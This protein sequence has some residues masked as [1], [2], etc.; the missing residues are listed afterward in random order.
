MPNRGSEPLNMAVQ[1]AS[2]RLAPLGQPNRDSSVTKGSDSDMQRPLF[3]LANLLY[4]HFQ[5]CMID[6]ACMNSVIYP[7][8]YYPLLLSCTSPNLVLMKG[9]VLYEG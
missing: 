7:F 9:S 3:S 4:L 1:L 8:L 2:V 6:N 5:H